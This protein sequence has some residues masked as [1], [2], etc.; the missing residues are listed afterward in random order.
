MANGVSIGLTMSDWLGL[1]STDAAIHAG[2][3]L[4]MPGPSRHRGTC[5]LRPWAAAKSPLTRSAP[6][7]AT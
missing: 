5:L 6:Q 3:D 4:E 2:L 1:H 7:L